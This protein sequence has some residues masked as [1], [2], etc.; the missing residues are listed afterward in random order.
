MF[1]APGRRLL[2]ELQKI[3]TWILPPV[4]RPEVSPGPVLVQPTYVSRASLGTDETDGRVPDI[5]TWYTVYSPLPSETSRNS[6]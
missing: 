2:R 6:R 5:W 1:V 4:T 3:M